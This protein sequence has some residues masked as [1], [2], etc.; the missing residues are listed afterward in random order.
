NQHKQPEIKQIIHA[1]NLRNNNE[2]DQE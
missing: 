1:K 2:N